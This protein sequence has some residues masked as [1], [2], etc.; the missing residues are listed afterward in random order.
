M[1]LEIRVM[2]LAVMSC[3]WQKVSCCFANHVLAL[4]S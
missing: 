1:I 2:N 4:R 3:K